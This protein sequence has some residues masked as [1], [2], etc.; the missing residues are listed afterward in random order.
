MNKWM[1]VAIS[2]GYMCAQAKLGQDSLV[3]MVIWIRWHCHPA[4]SS[5]FERLPTILQFYKWAGKKH[6]VLLK[7][8]SCNLQTVV[9]AYFS[10]HRLPLHAFARASNNWYPD[11]VVQSHAPHSHAPR[12][13]KKYLKMIRDRMGWRGAE[14]SRRLPGLPLEPP[15]NTRRWA[16]VGPTL[17]EH[18]FNASC[19]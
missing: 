5:K 6:F 16:S 3:K 14:R 12:I 7:A 15:A 2:L 19:S 8:L 18:W 10:N 1:N 9:P 11:H 4:I 13:D 17:T